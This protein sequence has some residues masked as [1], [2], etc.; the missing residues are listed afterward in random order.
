MFLRLPMG[1]VGGPAT[2]QRVI[3]K[4][5]GSLHRSV[6]LMYLDDII[7]FHMTANISRATRQNYCNAL[8]MQPEIESI[9]MYSSCK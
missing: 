8:E 5:L 2:F 6:A 7:L 4:V 9:E 3:E 1:V